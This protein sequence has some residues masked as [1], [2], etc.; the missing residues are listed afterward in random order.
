MTYTAFCLRQTGGNLY[1]TLRMFFLHTD[2]LH[3]LVGFRSI[4]LHQ[5][6]VDFPVSNPRGLYNKYLF[7]GPSDP[8]SLDFMFFSTKIC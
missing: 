4:D 6:F 7:S 3:N 2:R 5:T 1:N 8:P